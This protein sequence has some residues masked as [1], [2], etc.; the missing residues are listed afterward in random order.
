MEDFTLT[1]WPGK[2][3]GDLAVVYVALNGESFSKA[4]TLALTEYG[5]EILIPHLEWGRP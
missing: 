3:P 4:V 5:Q 1:N 2:K